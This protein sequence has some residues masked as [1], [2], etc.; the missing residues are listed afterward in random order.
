MGQDSASEIAPEFLFHVIGYAIAHGV[1]LIGQGE[2][3]LRVFPDDAVERDGHRRPLASRGAKRC[4]STSRTAR[5]DLPAG[6][7]TNVTLPTEGEAFE[8]FPAHQE[9]SPGG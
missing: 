3:G 7:T 9:M 8:S 6:Q 5:V 4:V 1:G 2:V